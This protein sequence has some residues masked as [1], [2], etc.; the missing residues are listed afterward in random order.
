VLVIK[1]KENNL[2]NAKDIKPEALRILLSGEPGSG[3]T[4]LAASFPN[5]HFVDLDDGMLTVRG[6]D[7]NYITIS[8]H[9][10]TDPDFL[11]IAEEL[12]K[13]KNGQTYATLSTFEKAQIVIDHWTKKLGAGDTLVID[14][15]TF[16]S[17]A[18]FDHVLAVEKPK[19]NRM[20]YGM[21]QKLISVTLDMIRQRPCNIILTAHKKLRTDENGNLLKVQPQTVGNALADIIPSHFDEYWDLDVEIKKKAGV[22]VK[23]YV[24][25]TSPEKK[26]SMKSRL[27][28]PD[29]IEDPSYTKI[30][31]LLK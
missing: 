10:T 23:T 8:E 17:Q 24:M 14:S 25:R 6:E 16:Y 11:A 26:Q 12:P 20:A 15:L 28:L 2:A 31:E 3:K 5:A 13:L 1:R 21:A 22:D 9:E 7:V 19:D 4:K 29:R 18:A 30:M 27:N